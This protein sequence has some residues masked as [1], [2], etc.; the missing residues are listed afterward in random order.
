M[1]NLSALFLRNLR[2]PAESG[3]FSALVSRKIE[4]HTPQGSIFHVKQSI[5]ALMLSKKE[6]EAVDEF[7]IVMRNPDSERYVQ[8][9]NRAIWKK[10]QSPPGGPSVL[11]LL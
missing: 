4:V 8:Y 9:T 7:T 10:R 6:A 2:T 3:S 11:Q 5:A 1:E